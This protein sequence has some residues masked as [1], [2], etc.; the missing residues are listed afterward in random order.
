MLTPRGSLKVALLFSRL[1]VPATT[2]A[3][4]ESYVKAPDESFGW[5]LTGE[6][7]L[8]GGGSALIVRLTSQ[9]WQGIL[10]EHWLSVVRPEKVTHPEHA[11][12]FITGGSKKSEPPK[13]ASEEAM[14][15]AK[16]ARETGSVIAVLAQVPNQPLFG[17]LREDA[18]ISHT[19]VKYMETKD[20]S[21]PCLLPMTKSAVR[22]MDAVQAI[23]KEKLSQQIRHFVVSGASKRGWTTWLTGA[24]DPRVIAIAPMVIDTL[25]MPE[26]MQ[27]QL[28]SFGGYSE[29]IHDY[30]D[31]NLPDQLRKPEG[32]HLVELVDP[33]SYRK[34]LTMPKL[35][36]LGTNDPYWPVDAVKLY[37]GGLEGE[38]HIHYVP[39]GDHG[40]GPGAV[41]A[42]AAFYNDVITGTPR[43]HFSWSFQRGK[44]E[45]TLTVEAQDPPIKAELW[46]SSAPTRDF[47]KVRW[48]PAPMARDGDGRF[49][50]K[51][52][53]PGEG[54]AAVLGQLTYK[55]ALGHEYTLSTNVEVLEPPGK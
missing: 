5:K 37:F 27:L 1:L 54:F 7:A 16:I 3:D 55:S 34:N 28:R 14:I 9:T 49:V 47:R 42:L 33:Y 20:D 45:A 24:V 11:L 31:R 19:F 41:E 25:N 53:A 29:M 51:V 10:W 38:K 2:R 39:N 36:L 48:S 12:L 15:F 52:P 23:A 30:S 21:W 6:M 44:T 13:R 32:K 17:D 46:Q 4:L 50:A 43:P 26:Q 22:A 35:I 40:L 8:P 18:L